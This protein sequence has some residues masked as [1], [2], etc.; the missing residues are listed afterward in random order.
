MN[1]FKVISFNIY[2]N[3]SCICI[4]VCVCVFLFVFV[5][6]F[7]FD[8]FVLF[9]HLDFLSGLSI[10]RL[11][12]PFHNLIGFLAEN[13]P[14]INWLSSFIFFMFFVFF[15]F[16]LFVFFLRIGFLVQNR[17]R[18]C[19]LLFFLNMFIFFY[20]VFL[21][22]F[23]FFLAFIFIFLLAFLRRAGHASVGSSSSFSKGSTL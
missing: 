21:L 12:P 22:P 6:S 3:L 1:I 15:V 17:P 5:F 10:C 2:S 18:I 4:C 20:F 9:S 14:H 8:L 16:Y 11:L 19:W 7:V 23:I 13:R